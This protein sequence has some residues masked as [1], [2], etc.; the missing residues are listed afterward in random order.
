MH[1]HVLT[2]QGYGDSSLCVWQRTADVE[3]CGYALCDSMGCLLEGMYVCV[4]Q[5]TVMGYGVSAQ[6]LELYSYPMFEYIAYQTVG[7]SI[8]SFGSWNI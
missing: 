2:M 6:P 1:V 3:G 5:T 4:T 7:T 8:H